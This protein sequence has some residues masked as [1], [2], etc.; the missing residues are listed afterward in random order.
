LQF[1]EARLANGLQIIAE[2]SP[3]VHSVAFGFF[4]RTGSRDETDE[5]SGVS[6]FLEHMVFKGTDRHSADDVNRIF[7]E[8]G[9]KYNAS[10]SEETTLFYA[11]V[12]PEYLPRS[13]DL[14][15]DIIRPSL[16]QEDFDME[17][18]VI[19]EEI[20]MYDDQ[21]TYTTYENLM[22]THFAGHPLGRSVLGTND[23]IGA[24]ACEQMRA[25]HQSRY[26]AGNILLAVAGKF[27]WPEV[28]ALAETGCAAW[29][30][31]GGPR[32]TNEPRPTGGIKLVT[33]AGSMLQ[34]VMH[35]APAPTADSPLRYAADILT[36]IV[37]DDSGSRMFWELVDPGHAESCE[38]GYN[39]FDGSGAYMGY[40]SCPPEE[41]RANV[42]RVQA[43]YDDVNRNGVS[44][45]ELAQ[46]KSKISSR[47]V[48]RSERPMGR[49]SS[50]GHNWINR[51]EYHRVED[52]LAIV[53]GIT[54]A[55]IHKLIEAYP[56]SQL[57]TSTVGPLESLSG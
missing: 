10:T 51:N 27:D 52:D 43:I 5:V 2:Q 4:V 47:V 54:L 55:D 42:E 18:K 24:L 19:L 25:Y 33:K 56:L 6:H 20:G 32:S 38:L 8:V 23:S 41:A 1:H 13:F 28:L 11:A 7:D 40:L 26:A 3:S 57:S 15:A 16:R 46:A 44:E 21:P 36:V 31:G 22:Q 34:H 50:L 30:A 49:L 12:L 37:G 53:R 17:K 39:E 48:L 45:V 9:A 14:L 29:P 35:M